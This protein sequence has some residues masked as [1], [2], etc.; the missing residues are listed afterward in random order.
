MG[1]GGS[2]NAP[3]E[4][5]GQPV[6]LRRMDESAGSGQQ[7][8]HRTEAMMTPEIRAEFLRAVHRAFGGLEY[9]VIG[10][11]AM[12]EYGN[13]RATSDVDIMVPNDISEVVEANL[14]SRGMVRTV[15]GGLG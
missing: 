7:H 11:V 13:Q 14:L 2:K 10:G 4:G 3:Y 12:A 6:P 8:P 1:C 9:G 5:P 15:G